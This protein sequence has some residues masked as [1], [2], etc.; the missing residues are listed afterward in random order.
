[1]MVF[2]DTETICLKLWDAFIIIAHVKNL[3]MPSQ[4]KKFR[5]ANETELDEQWKQ[6]IQEKGYNV[7]QM[8]K[9]DWWKINKRENNVEEY[10]RE[11]F[12]FKMSL[13]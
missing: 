11:S 2:V 6:Y 4:R 7:V 13:R 9:C 10:L 1:M 12:L 3:V 8:Y 5:Q